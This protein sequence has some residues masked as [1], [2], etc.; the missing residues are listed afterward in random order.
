MNGT[1]NKNRT[2]RSQ[3]R[4][5]M[6]LAT[7]ELVEIL[8]DRR[9][10]IT[11][12]MMPLLVYPLMGVVVQKLLLQTLSGN[13]EVV[14]NVGFNSKEQAGE[15]TQLFL[16][17]NRA[18]ESMESSADQAA[19]EPPQTA[20]SIANE[21]ESGDVAAPN[22]KYFFTESSLKELVGQHIIDIGVVVHPEKEAG[23]RFEIVHDPKSQFSYDAMQYVG[24]RLRTASD[25]VFKEFNRRFL[26]AGNLP[27]NLPG[28]Y[29]ESRV[30]S[31]PEQPALLTF[32]P[33]M[34]VLMTITGAVY[35]AIDLTAG[36]RERGTM[37]IL[38]AAPIPRLN[39]LV[40]KF[41]A[42]F[43]VAI[44]TALA[45]LLAMVVTIYTLGLDELIFGS[46]SLSPLTFVVI[47][48][49]LL[50]LA[51]FF[52]AVLLGMTSFA[53][54]FKEAQAYLIPLMLIAFAPGL[55]SLT[56]NLE[57][58]SSLA[59]IPLV[60]IVL[61]GRDLLAGQASPILV[62]V[63]MVSTIMYG[64]LALAFASRVF[65]EDSILTGGMTSW[66][67]L[68]S[69]R[70]EYRDVPEFSTAMGFLAVLFPGFIVLSGLVTNF[71]LK[72]EATVQQM[73]WFNAGVTAVLF[74]GLPML[75]SYIGWLRKSSTFFWQRPTILSVIGAGL[76]GCAVWTLAYEL[77]MFSLSSQRL[78]EFLGLFESMKISMKSIPLPV[79][80]ICLAVVPA[81][82][83][84]IT[85]R[86]FLLSAFVK[87]LPVTI[88]VLLT[89]FLFGLFHVFVRDV[90]VFE[91]M[92]PSSFMGILLGYVCVRSGSI[93]PGMILHVIHN[94]LL[95]TISHHEE[96][97]VDWGIGM[98]EQKHLPIE[99]VLIAIVPIVI[100][101]L[102]L[103]FSKPASKQSA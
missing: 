28:S 71:A 32:I 99:W 45:N 79:K 58:T 46:Q 36:E 47:F 14:Y 29:V 39:I 103:Q 43:S 66:S 1:P 98:S 92:I 83:E 17:G 42:V 38:V 23:S 93:I 68:F 70:K 34:L 91:R 40:G 6:R 62:A 2:N 4:R 57:T 9:T 84:E 90:L 73:L 56:P 61:A 5:L 16:L 100:G 102:L 96:K 33:L 54:S 51:A 21:L 48:L 24:R 27:T 101:F 52:S 13:Q 3:L 75:F 37:E 63:T 53:R 81:V 82:C 18:I 44:L 74:V 41:I 55:L 15:F 31:E 85:F 19:N 30:E 10:I 97:L 12:V 20:A 78:T 86:G 67:D 88:A 77:E 60:N 22:M 35:P 26:K 11:L 59:V 64:L 65:G 72:S 25:E 80:L 8:R 49:L 69:G 50:V 89:A 95:I 7:K 87:R 94:G 76:L